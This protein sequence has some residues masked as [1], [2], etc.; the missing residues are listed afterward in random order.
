MGRN[1]RIE[2]THARATIW[3]VNRFTNSAILKDCSKILRKKQE[4]IIINKKDMRSMEETFKNIM[5]WLKDF[6]IDF[7]LQVKELFL[8]LWDFIY[9]IFTNGSG[10]SDIDI[11]FIKTYES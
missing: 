11:N 6:F 10:V 9:G 3:C 5:N 8:G 2:L 4:Y 1:V 7:A